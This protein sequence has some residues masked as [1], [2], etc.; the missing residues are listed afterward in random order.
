MANA[1]L[2]DLLKESALREMA[3]ERSYERGLGYMEDGRVGD[4]FE[5]TDEITATVSGARKYR[6][7]L[8]V[9][10]GALDYSCTCPMGAGGHFCKHCVATAL[11][12]REQPRGGARNVAK[13]KDRTVTLQD[14]RAMLLSR[15]HASLV[16]SLLAWAKTDDILC[17]RLLLAAAKEAKG[18]VNL[19]T[20][21]RA[22]DAAIEIGDFV[23]YHEMAS[24][25]RNADEVVDRIE[26]VLREGHADAAIELSEHALKACERALESMDDSDGYMGGILDRL[27]EIHLQACEAAK[28]DPV[29]LARKLF[30][31]EMHS[32]WEVFLGAAEPYSKV[33]GTTGME[34]YR[35]L[36]EAEWAKVPVRPPASGESG[37]YERHFTIT[38]IME[39]LARL[40]GDVEALVAVISRDLSFGYSFLQIAQVYQEAGNKDKALAWAE[41]GL[42]AFP[43]RTDS[44]LREFVA[45]EYH[46]RK[47]HEE[48][49]GLIWANFLDQPSLETYKE[50]AAH[51]K[52]AGSWRTWRDQALAEIRKDVAEAKN[53]AAKQGRFISRYDYDTGHSPLVRIFLYEED[54]DTA[55]R[56]ANEG[57]CSAELWLELAKLREKDHP[58]DS[59]RIYLAQV[60]PLVSQKNNQAYAQAVA[61]LRKARELMTRMGQK[62]AFDDQA[63]VIRATHKPK[64]NFIQLLNKAGL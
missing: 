5:D 29:A 33:L 56:E 27:Q 32:Q 55:W 18:G 23:D 42:R 41:K 17:E 22:I 11:T 64:R 46:R 15:D 35:K 44:R 34:V 31:W 25:A 21:R 10:E 40:T 43:E 1:S 49:V 14:V 4:L 3:G 36:A 8:W 54:V 50:L 2:H 13:T 37:T 62:Q 7:R 39:T 61:L 24:Y 9:E 51:S 30:A 6:V 38:R 52:K 19:A 20:F 57:G 63:T 28:P 12:W 53:R 26:E 59:A 47:R 60:E 45:S 16:D 58:E 48:A